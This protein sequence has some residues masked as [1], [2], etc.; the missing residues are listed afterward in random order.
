MFLQGAS[1]YLLPL[2]RHVLSAV[3]HDIMRRKN[4]GKTNISILQVT[5]TV[6]LILKF[7]VISGVKIPYYEYD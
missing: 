4:I 6:M 2:T 7:P 5:I 3:M 1:V